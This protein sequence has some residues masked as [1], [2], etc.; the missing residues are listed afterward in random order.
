MTDLQKGMTAPDFTLGNFTLSQELKKSPLL[1]TF[2]KKTCP[3]CQFTY[4]FLERLHKKFTSPAFKIIGI[5]QDPETHEFAAHYVITFPL[6]SDTPTY[7]VSKQYHLTT[8]PSIVLIQQNG[9]ID[10][11]TIGFSKE[12]LE[13]LSQ[14]ISQLTAQTPFD[15][16]SKSDTVPAFKPG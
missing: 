3:T 11:L 4:P 1:L 16:F 12:E 15:I 2:Y 14:K 5:G 9:T 7:E 10:F 6:V 8:V 13:A